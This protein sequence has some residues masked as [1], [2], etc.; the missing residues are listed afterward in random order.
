M[1]TIL[2]LNLIYINDCLTSTIVD[3]NVAAC[4][5]RMKTWNDQ[6]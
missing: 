2:R 1:M 3:L 5:M 6:E 4:T